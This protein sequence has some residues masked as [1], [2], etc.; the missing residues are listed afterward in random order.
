MLPLF[1]AVAVL[2]HFA[3]LNMAVDV[4]NLYVC[5]L[6]FNNSKYAIPFNLSN[7]VLLSK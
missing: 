5:S 6:A 3:T 4:L 2:E 7:L 1:V